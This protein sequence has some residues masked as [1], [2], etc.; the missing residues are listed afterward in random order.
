M[1]NV[2]FNDTFCAYMFVMYH[3]PQL[4]SGMIRYSNSVYSD[5]TTCLK[6][7]GMQFIK[8]GGG[9]IEIVCVHMVTLSFQANQ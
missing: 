5:S 8:K 7:F 3:M 4:P 6:T 1:I 9:S 2:S